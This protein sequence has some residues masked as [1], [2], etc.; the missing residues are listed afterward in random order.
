MQDNNIFYTTEDLAEKLKVSERSIRDCLNSGKLKGYKRFNK[1]YIF[2]EDLVKFLK[3]G[4][5]KD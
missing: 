1:W 3:G 5:V 4:V 2:E